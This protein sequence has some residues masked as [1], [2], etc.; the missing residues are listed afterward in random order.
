MRKKKTFQHG[1]AG[2]KQLSLNLYMHLLKPKNIVLQELY[3]MNTWTQWTQWR[4][5]LMLRYRGL[6][7]P[8]KMQKRKRLL[9]A[10]VAL[11]KV[12]TAPRQENPWCRWLSLKVCAVKLTESQCSV[13]SLVCLHLCFTEPLSYAPLS[14]Y[15][16]HPTKWA[17]CWGE[18]SVVL[19]LFATRRPFLGTQPHYVILLFPLAV[20]QPVLR[21]LMK[22]MF[23]GRVLMSSVWHVCVHECVCMCS[24]H[25]HLVQH[26]FNRSPHFYL[27]LFVSQMFR[28]SI[29][30]HKIQLRFAIEKH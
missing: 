14:V 18:R 7:L 5:K 27:Q 17:T 10:Q 1:P 6:M 23:A 4:R 29:E 12:S 8:L 11:Q 20:L 22:S 25:H 9:Q 21:W 16:K 19:Q 30:L 13:S 2:L 3:L 26:C 28:Q 15:N 24:Q